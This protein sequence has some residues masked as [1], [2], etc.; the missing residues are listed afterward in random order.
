MPLRLGGGTRLKVL[1][2]LALGTPVVATPKGVEG[3]DLRADTD[4]MVGA[5]LRSFA[6]KTLALL[7]DAGLR[8]QLA[9]QGRRAVTRYDWAAI[10]KQLNALLAETVTRRQTSVPHKR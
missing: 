3:L 10:G 1:E 8:Q 2:S 4:V 7:S 9:V 5:D 6:D